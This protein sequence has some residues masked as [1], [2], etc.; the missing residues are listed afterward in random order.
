MKIVD[1]VGHDVP[2]VHSF[3]KRIKKSQIVACGQTVLPD[4]TFKDDDMLCM[5]TDRP[6]DPL[7]TP[8]F[9]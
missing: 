7:M 3:L 4:S 5:V 9:K 8:S 6:A 1:R 2:G